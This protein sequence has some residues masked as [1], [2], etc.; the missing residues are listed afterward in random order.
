MQQ[1]VF[2]NAPNF[3]DERESIKVTKTESP[4]R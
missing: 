4:M 3:K 2:K 1:R